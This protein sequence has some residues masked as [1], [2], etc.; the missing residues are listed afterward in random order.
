MNERHRIY[1]KKAA[2]EPKPWS[3]DPVFQQYKF[4]NVYR[5]LDRG[6]QW[7]HTNFIQPHGDEVELLA[8][9]CAWYRMFNFWGTGEYLGWQTGWDKVRIKSLLT[10]RLARGEQ[11]FTG[12]HI[13]RSEFGR[14]KIDSI[15]DVCTDL[16]YM[17]LAGGALLTTCREEKR[18]QVAFEGLLTV[19]YIGPFMAHEIVIDWRH[20]PLLQD[21]IDVNTWSNAGPGAKRGLERLGL[22]FSPPAEALASM[23]GLL[24][25]QQLES[26]MPAIELHQIEFCLCEFDKMC[27][28]YYDEG[29]RPRSRYAGI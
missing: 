2:G 27:R 4:T 6:T 8:F 11:V 13:V 18:L 26:H 5:N 15:V 17:C 23:I 1:L 7:L 14:P 21:A 3:V 24:K 25:R 9:N 12:A 20:T 28:V 29:S 16:Y 19:P 10:A 22:P